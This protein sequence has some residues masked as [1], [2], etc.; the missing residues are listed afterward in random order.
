MTDVLD[1]I[2]NEINSY[3][4]G[5]KKVASFLT[6][7]YDRAVFMTAAKIAFETGVSEST[8]VRFANALGFDGFP[9]L[10]DA[11]RDNVKS[12]ITSLQRFEHTLE[13]VENKDILS[14]VVSSDISKLKRTL[15]QTDN[16]MFD[17]AVN[18]IISAKKIYIMGIRSSSAL[19]SFLGFYFSIMFDDVR[20]ISSNTMSESFE[21]MLKISKDDVFIGISYPRYSLRTVKALKYAKANNAKVIA[22]TDTK[23]S[24]LVEYSDITLLA[25]SEMVSFVD[26][27]VAPISI[28]NALIVALGMNK[29]DELSQAFEKLEKIWGEYKVY[30]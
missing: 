24:P 28:I 3:S 16:D 13:N 5:Q 15:E 23:T 7:Q 14:Y 21:Q 18:A 10:L 8:V 19:A 27:L 4:K 11:L 1:K 6:E 25:E 2:K 30:K 29:R 12:K 20:V 17:R 26:S 9:E 22:L